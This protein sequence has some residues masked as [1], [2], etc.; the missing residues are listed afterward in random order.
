MASNAYAKLI[1]F[2]KSNYTKPYVVINTK[3]QIGR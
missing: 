2:S 3:L 1:M